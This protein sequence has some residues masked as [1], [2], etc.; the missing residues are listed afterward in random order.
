MERYEEG[1]LRSDAAYVRQRH[2]CVHCPIGLRF[3]ELEKRKPCLYQQRELREIILSTRCTHTRC[4]GENIVRTPSESRSLRP[5]GGG[6]ISNHDSPRVH[7]GGYTG[8]SDDGL[9]ARL[10]ARTSSR[11]APA[12]GRRADRASAFA[13]LLRKI[14]CASRVFSHLSF[15]SRHTRP[16]GE[17]LKR[18]GAGGKRA[19][20]CG[21]R[22]TRPGR[23]AR[24]ATSSPRGAGTSERR[25]VRSCGRALH[26]QTRARVKALDAVE[27]SW[28]HLGNHGRQM[29]DGA[30]RHRSGPHGTGCGGE[31]VSAGPNAEHIMLA[32]APPQ[33]SQLRFG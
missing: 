3:M 7:N 25:N 31:K 12:R 28:Y 10:N 18:R 1:A 5:R 17:G 32:V 9:A 33:T 14:S 4:R 26:G 23:G 29:D 2:L 8:G 16:R 27:P 19:E 13:C 6:R 22:S 21:S 11:H 20:D 30:P 24:Q 15:Q